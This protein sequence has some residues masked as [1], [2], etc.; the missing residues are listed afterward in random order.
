LAKRE[1]RP[2]T[3]VRTAPPTSK[4]A[5]APTKALRDPPTSKPAAAPTKALCAAAPIKALRAA[6]PTKALRAA[7]PTKAL[8]DAERLVNRQTEKSE[9]NKHLVCI[10]DPELGRWSLKIS[11]CK[12]FNSVSFFSSNAILLKNK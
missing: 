4:P 1:P 3:K 11:Q 2:P 6:A 12:F 7:A 10:V 8:R 9:V 5:A